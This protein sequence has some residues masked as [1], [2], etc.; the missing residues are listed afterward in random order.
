[1]KTMKLILSAILMMVAM[2][3]QAQTIQVMKDG[4][5]VKEYAASEV[6]SVVVK[7]YVDRNVYSDAACTQKLFDASKVV[8]GETSLQGKQWADYESYAVKYPAD[9][10]EI[11]MKVPFIVYTKS[12]SGQLEKPSNGDCK[13]D[14]SVYWTDGFRNK[15]IIILALQ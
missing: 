12:L 3:V 14:G 13:Q 5:V 11:N 4:K 10:D 6:D 2:C 8:T 15:T 9:K 1:M 7:P